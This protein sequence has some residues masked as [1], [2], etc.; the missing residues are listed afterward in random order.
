M[1]KNILLYGYAQNKKKMQ[2]KLL[3]KASHFFL[4]PPFQINPEYF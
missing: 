2:G 1:C 4:F 3:E